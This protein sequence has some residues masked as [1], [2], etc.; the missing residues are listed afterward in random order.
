MKCLSFLILCF[1]LTDSFKTQTQSLD[2]PLTNKNKGFNLLKK[3]GWKEGQGIGKEQGRVEPIMPIQRAER[4]G[5]GSSGI[6][7]AIDSRQQKKSE[8]LKKTQERFEKFDS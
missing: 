3:A 6:S 7:I 2:Q 1:F 4:S 5:L 8:I